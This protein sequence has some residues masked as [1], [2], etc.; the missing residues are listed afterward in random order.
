M[1]WDDG[2]GTARALDAWLVLRRITGDYETGKEIEEGQW[3]YLRH[4][5]HPETGLVYVADLSVPNRDGYYY[6]LWDQGRTLRHLINRYEWPF[7]SETE[8]ARLESL[9]VSMINGLKHLS[10]TRRSEDGTSAVYWTHEVYRDNTPASQ[11]TD[12]GFTIGSAQ[13][14]DPATRWATLTGSEENL[15]WAIQLANGFVAGLEHRRESTTPMFGGKGEF[16]GHFHCAVSGLVG[17]VHLARAL[18]LRKRS[19]LGKMYLD[20]AIRAYQ[21]IFSEEN[22]NRGSSHGWFPES[23]VKRQSNISEICCTADMI[24]LAAALASTAGLYE[25]Y[26]HLDQ[27]WDDVDRFTRNEL[28]R[29]QILCPEKLAHWL[30]PKT[31][32]SHRAFCAVAER[33]RGG[34]SFG[35]T[36]PHDLMDFDKDRSIEGVLPDQPVVNAEHIRMPIGGCCLYSGPRGLFACCDAA[37]KEGDEEIKLRF[38]MK[39]E[40]SILTMDERPSGGL[41]YT[42]KQARKIFVRIPSKV[43]LK[44]VQIFENGQSISLAYD[45]ASNRVRIDSKPGIEYK[46]TWENPVWESYETL[47]P[48]NDGHIPELPVGSRITYKLQFHGNQLK[49]LMPCEGACLS[50]KDGL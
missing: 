49:E 46:V 42:L 37:V 38:P 24:E 3:R 27:Y 14:L 36:W 20:T 16:Y 40:C 26:E 8:R 10:T 45:A 28:F 48:A 18:M 19:S 50:Y 34:W 47:G 44:T 23:S 5:L 17:L 1:Q 29:M 35:H 32:A 11:S 13:M 33:F 4:L 30:D 43:D 31:P 2:D 41:S 25:G 9:I 21:W 6:H 7:T 15:E 22:K 12:F 39:Y